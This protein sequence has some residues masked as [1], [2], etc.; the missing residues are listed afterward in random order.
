MTQVPQMCIV[1][2]EALSLTNHA[3][4]P[5]MTMHMRTQLYPFCTFISYATLCNFIV[6]S[7]DPGFHHTGIGWKLGYTQNMLLL[8]RTTPFYVR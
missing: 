5:E 6:F 1:T 2:M 7:V 4:F 8:A 3:L